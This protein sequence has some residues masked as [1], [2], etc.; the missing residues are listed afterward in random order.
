MDLTETGHQAS[1]SIK[2]II[3]QLINSIVIPLMVKKDN[4]YG[5]KGLV[6]DVFY[7]ALINAITGPILKYIN[8][9]HLFTRIRYWYKSSPRNY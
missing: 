5:E 1:L 4:V 2:S 6:E 9:Y 8:L 7:M 3:A